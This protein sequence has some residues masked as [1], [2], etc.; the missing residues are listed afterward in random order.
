MNW[1]I[2][3]ALI[4]FLIL[5]FAVL[6]M[7]MYV[8]PRTHTPPYIVQDV[9]G[10]V[11]SF[12]VAPQY[13]QVPSGNITVPSH[14]SNVDDEARIYPSGMQIDASGNLLYPFTYASYQ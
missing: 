6:N 14:W 4:F 12:P 11:A 9:S 13:G 2:G 10:A 1:R 3:I 5:L 7:A 8:I